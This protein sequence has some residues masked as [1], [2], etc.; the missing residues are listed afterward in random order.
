MDRGR[1]MD[2][3]H[4]T[5]DEGVHSEHAATQGSPMN[6]DPAKAIARLLDPLLRAM[7]AL[8]FVARHLYPPELD[9]SMSSIGTPDHDLKM[10]Q[11]AQTK[12]PAHLSGIGATLNE[13]TEATLQ[14]FAGLRETVDGSSDVRRAY[15]ALLLATKGIEALYPLAR[16][17]PQVNRFFLDPQIWSDEEF[18]RQFLRGVAHRRTGPLCFDNDGAERGGY[19]LYKPE[20]YTPARRWQIVM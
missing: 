8:G 19:W 17:L 3:G 2:C 14:A 20:Y 6:E 16:V 10:A 7:E 13:A 12:W 4:P 11:A 9:D 1:W 15:R 5:T 18:Q